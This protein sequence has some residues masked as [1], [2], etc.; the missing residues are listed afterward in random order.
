M[1][2]FKYKNLILSLGLLCAILSLIS[3]K[4]EKKIPLLEYLDI[5]FIFLSGLWFFLLIAIIL[6]FKNR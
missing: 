6:K 5:K 3:L 2:L 1:F 4:L